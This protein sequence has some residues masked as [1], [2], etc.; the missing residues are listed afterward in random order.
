MITKPLIAVTMVAAVALA[1]CGSSSSQTVNAKTAAALS[2]D[3]NASYKR[4]L[5]TSLN[6]LI[7]ANRQ[8]STAMVAL[9]GSQPTRN[10]IRV[11]L[12]N[13]QTTLVATKGAI[14]TITAPATGTS[15]SQTIDQALSQ[16]NGYLQVVGATFNDPT[17]N[18]AS[19]VQPLAT[20]LQSALVP[21][22]VVVPTAQTS[23]FGPDN[24]YSWSQGAASQAAKKK[25]PPQFTIVNPPAV[26]NP[27]R[28]AVT[29]GSSG[30]DRQGYAYEPNCSDNP[31][32]AAPSCFD[33]TDSQGYNYGLGCS[34]NPANSKPGCADSFSIPAGD[35]AVS[36]PNGITADGQTTSEGLAESVHANY[37][38][39]GP[40]TGWSSER[41]QSYTFDCQT[42]GSGTTGYTICQG[43]AGNSSLYLRWHQ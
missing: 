32:N 18:S 43:Q 23:V 12:K 21:L 1:G 7:D 2:A 4:Q 31:N 29:P 8:L 34:D 30:S 35:L 36:Y 38:S 20:S 19:Q 25:T 15:L 40:V 13:A 17:G 5:G 39:D 33:G 14:S 6:L 41:Q 37:T 11:T 28:L 26:V 24:F 42:G 16:E 10:A 22:S 3:A 27:P 9:D